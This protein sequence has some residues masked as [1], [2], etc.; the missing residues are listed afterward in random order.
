[1]GLNLGTFA[2]NT[3]HSNGRFGLRVFELFPR[4]FPCDPERNPLKPDPFVDNPSNEAIFE[5]FTTWK[6]NEAGVLGERLGMVTFR[7]FKIADSKLAGY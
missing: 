6:N 4:K 3:A 1:M 7:N 2:N 5:N